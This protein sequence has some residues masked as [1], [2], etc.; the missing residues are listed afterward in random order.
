MADRTSLSRATESS[1]A[2]TPGYLYLDIARAASSSQI[3]E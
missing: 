3:P 2:P 1:D